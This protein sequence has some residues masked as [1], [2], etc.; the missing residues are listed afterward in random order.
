[1]PLLAAYSHAAGAYGLLGQRKVAEAIT[2]AQTAVNQAP[3]SAEIR[4]MSA[5]VLM[6]VGRKAEAQ[7]ALAEA[8]RVARASHPDYRRSLIRALEHPGS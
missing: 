1:V 3:N 7:E 8:L 2:E 5:Q 6:A 4:A